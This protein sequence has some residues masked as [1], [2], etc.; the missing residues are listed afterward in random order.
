MSHEFN[1][2]VQKLFAH[3]RKHA[4][5]RHILMYTTNTLAM[6]GKDIGKCVNKSEKTY[7][8]YS[9]THTDTLASSRPG[10]TNDIEPHSHSVCQCSTRFSGFVLFYHLRSANKKG[11]LVCVY[12]RPVLIVVVHT[13]S[14]NFLISFGYIRWDIK[15]VSLLLRRLLIIFHQF[16]YTLFWVVASTNT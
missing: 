16:G 5:W 14:P 9:H 13:N 7:H 11:R 3:T 1:V 10:H 6:G 12:T 4:E 15:F 2:F 8:I